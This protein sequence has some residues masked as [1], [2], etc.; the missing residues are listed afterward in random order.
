VKKRR[1]IPGRGKRKNETSVMGL[2]L[3]RYAQARCCGSANTGFAL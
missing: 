1:P 3:A 2:G